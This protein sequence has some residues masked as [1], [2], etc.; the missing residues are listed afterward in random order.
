MNLLTF[1]YLPAAAGLLCLI[2]PR[3]IKYAQEAIA[4]LAAS[5]FLFL[6]FRAF[7]LPDETLRI[8][9]FSIPPLD[10]SLD[11]RLVHFSKFLLIFLGLF[12][13]LTALYSTGYFRKK[14]ISQ[15]YF[16]FVLW[17]LCGASGIV[18]ANNFFVLLL[19]WEF[20]TL[21]LFFLIAMGQ[22]KAAS[23]AAGK[24]FAM[25]G[26]TDVALLLAVVA[27][28]LI[29]GSWKISELHI[30]LNT[31]FAIVIFLL[32]F[33]AAIAKAG[34]IPF[35][36]WIPPAAQSGPLP[37][38]AFLPASLDKL[39][40]IYLLA[41]ITL[42]VFSIPIGSSIS[43]LIMVIGAL[44]II[45]AVLI[46]VVQHDLKRLLS[47]HAISQVGYM[48][49][50]IGTGNPI[51]IAGGL[52]HMLNHAIYKSSLFFSAGAV[53]RQTGTTDV[54]K[55]GGLGKYMPVTF[56]ACLVASLSISGVP[57]FNGFVSK[58]MIY[59]GLVEGRSWIY[60]VFLAVAMFGSA[61]TLASFLKLLYGPFM[62]ERFRSESASKSAAP[63]G[64][65]EVHWTML[66]PMVIL[67]L[68]C[69]GF[70]LFAQYPINQYIGPIL[71]IKFG[72]VLHS[73][74]IGTA[75]WNP[76][77]A[78]ILLIFG[79]IIGAVFYFLSRRRTRSTE[80]IFIGGE[81]FVVDRERSLAGNFYEFLERMGV[82]GG[83]LKESNKGILDIYNLS[84]DFGL[85]FVGVLKKLHDGVLSTYLAWC[86]IGL[87][88]LSF[89]LMVL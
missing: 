47:Y 60:M 8:P 11:F 66:V 54:D 36:S 44:T 72:S 23:M 30:V 68:L 28:P 52:F 59:Q 48:V 21:L 46:A 67:S 50:G 63:R 83:F 19:G 55:L 35:H 37:V 20:V 42:N 22:G 43:I 56:L 33:I 78:T 14:S 64:I 57:P 73:I 6:S 31:P 40:G 84:G 89:V 29:Y 69:I 34:A 82:I 26:F 16:P 41:L 74:N 25:L 9:W 70:G 1:I 12:T 18:L 39:L 58:W 4:I 85:I 7:S 13:L 88:V 3:K 80:T 27:L 17:T 76:T 49:L 45:V 53:E 81:K 79:L 86:V 62:G 65:K 71:D 75:F 2:I 61:L 38:I 77:I 51:G 32:M 87:G 15:L 10:F 24:T 5:L